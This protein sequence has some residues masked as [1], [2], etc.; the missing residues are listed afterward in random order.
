MSDSHP[1]L[2]FREAQ[3][4]L[5]IPISVTFAEW[6]K[7]LALIPEI[8]G[9]LAERGIVPA[10]PLFFRYAVIG[11]MKDEPFDLE[12]GFPVASGVDGDERVRVGE[13]PAGIYATSIHTGH[14]DG[15]I[16]TCAGL[17]AWGGREGVCFASNPQDGR[18]AWAGRYEFYLSDPDEVP[19]MHDWQTEVAFLTQGQTP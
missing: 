17:L 18:E 12:I 9:W 13:I 19:D 2:E 14:P 7:A 11:N 6:D 8:G 3:R 16:G 15:L 5:A 1:A 4:S 10:G